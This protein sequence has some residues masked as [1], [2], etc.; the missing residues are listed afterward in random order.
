MVERSEG[1]M[2]IDKT[3]V[4]ELQKQV[5][6]SWPTGSARRR[7]TVGPREPVSEVSRARARR[8]EGKERSGEK[9]RKGKIKI[10][11]ISSQES[12]MMKPL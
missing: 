10:R 7:H 9:K 12:Q 6:N 1:K 5:L 4:S 2:I 11:Q 8:R 3:I